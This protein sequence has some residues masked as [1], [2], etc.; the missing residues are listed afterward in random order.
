MKVKIK[1]KLKNEQFMEKDTHGDVNWGTVWP[2]TIGR[3]SKPNDDGLI[4]DSR[5]VVLK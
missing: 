3:P 5:G 4:R 2:K 1:A